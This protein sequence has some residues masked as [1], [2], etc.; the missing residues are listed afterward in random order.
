MS[1]SGIVRL[2]GLTDADRLCSTP[3]PS[4]LL[5]EASLAFRVPLIAQ[6]IP[7]LSLG[8]QCFTFPCAHEMAFG[9]RE[10]QRRAPA[11]GDVPFVTQRIGRLP[12]AAPFGSVFS[13]HHLTSRVK[14]STPFL[15]THIREK[16][17]VS[18]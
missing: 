1:G 7:Q 2:S 11:A 17:S 9:E 3:I 15:Y 8:F 6:M 4:C 12:F 14:D 18:E 10:G 16:T 5:R 13:G